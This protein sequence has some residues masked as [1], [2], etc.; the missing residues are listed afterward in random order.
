M[1]PDVKMHVNPDTHNKLAATVKIARRRRRWGAD[2]D[3]PDKDENDIM[4]VLRCKSF[5]LIVV[6]HVFL[7]YLWIAGSASTTVPLSCDSK[8]CG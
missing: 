8:L 1:W 4:S 2:Q 3:L 5:W 6:V 7:V